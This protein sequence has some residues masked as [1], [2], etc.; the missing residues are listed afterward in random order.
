MAR[1]RCMWSKTC[2]SFPPCCYLTEVSHL[3]GGKAYC[4]GGGFYI[5][6]IFPE[7]DVKA[8]VSDEPT[9]AAIVVAQRRGAASIRRSIITR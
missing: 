2:R 6:P 3:S 8:I 1:R 9:V 4:F 7:Y 5:D